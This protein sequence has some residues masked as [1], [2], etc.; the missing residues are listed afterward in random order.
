[1]IE[2]LLVEPEELRETTLQKVWRWLRSPMDLLLYPIRATL[3]GMIVPQS[4]IDLN[5][6]NRCGVN[7]KRQIYSE[8]FGL[9]INRIDYSIPGNNACGMEI[10]I[11]SN[12]QAPIGERKLVISFT[13]NAIDART[14]TLLFLEKQNELRSQAKPI[15]QNDF[16]SVDWPAYAT[17]SDQ[18]VDA[19]VSAVIRAI[20]AGYK[21]ENI[22]IVGHSLGG[23]VSAKVLE[24]MKD[25]PEVMQGQKFAGYV[26][27][28]SFSKIGDIIAAQ[29]LFSMDNSLLKNNKSFVETT[30]NSWLAWFLNLI[31][32]LF[33]VQINSEKIFKDGD[34]PVS[35]M[36]FYADNKDEIINCGAS[37]AQRIKQLSKRKIPTK[38]KMT[39]A[40]G[41]NNEFTNS[42][43]KP[44][45]N[46]TEWTASRKRI[47][48]KYVN[49]AKLRVMP[50]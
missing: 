21:T 11:N 25:Y 45:K 8:K 44:S 15:Y 14:N 35:Q 6:Q 4:W 1:M 49:V 23:A 10:V 28:R 31:A 29:V 30:N 16:L 22:T 47:S 13:G 39:S 20:K 24:K 3:M 33:G 43:Y 37:I 2:K 9:I 40:H 18:L 19:G 42:L 7:Y 36:K 5:K 46:W 26:N 41:H 27:H 12:N 34:L 17:T 50:Y 48:K 38:I 32:S